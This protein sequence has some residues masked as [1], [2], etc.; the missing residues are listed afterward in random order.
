MAEPNPNDATETNDIPG[1]GKEKGPKSSCNKN[2]HGVFANEEE[3]SM[4]ISRQ[5][6]QG[7]SREQTFIN[8]CFIM[9]IPQ[10][11]PAQIAHFFQC[12]E[13]NEGIN[14]IHLLNE[15]YP[16]LAHGITEEFK[17]LQNGIALW[18]SK[19]FDFFKFLDSRYA[20]AFKRTNT[21]EIF[22]FVILD[23]YYGQE[24]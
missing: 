9:N 8:M 22:Q 3:Y 12:M 4:E 11:I 21:L 7:Y 23:N 5:F 14:M 10:A 18:S 16:V 13:N 20:V 17:K 24:K 6:Q 15:Y 2:T 1:T 19:T